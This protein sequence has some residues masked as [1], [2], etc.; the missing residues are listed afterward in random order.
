MAGRL[1][2]TNIR[3]HHIGNVDHLPNSHYDLV[4]RPLRNRVPPEAD[5]LE[6]VWRRLSRWQMIF[7]RVTDTANEMGKP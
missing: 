3:R 4:T 2:A 1:L 5:R 6:R 7:R